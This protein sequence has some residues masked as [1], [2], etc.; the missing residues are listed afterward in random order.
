MEAAGVKPNIKTFTTMIRGWARASLPEKALMYFDEMK[1][2]GLKPDNA[3]YHCLMTSLLSR[4]TASEYV[5]SGI[6]SVCREMVDGELTV[7]MGTAV[8][9]SKCLLKIERAGGELTE[10]L[11]KTFPPA[12]NSSKLVFTRSDQIKIVDAADRNNF[13]NRYS[14]DDDDLYNV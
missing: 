7:D 1:R 6:L 10:A 9:W 8:H 11:Q 4:S 5:F 2:R 14:D 3:V 12:W 13:E